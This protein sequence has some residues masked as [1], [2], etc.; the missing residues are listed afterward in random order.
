PEKLPLSAK[1]FWDAFE[2]GV[3]N[4][5]TTKITNEEEKEQIKKEQEQQEMIAKKS[6]QLEQ[7]QASERKDELVNTIKEKMGNIRDA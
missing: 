5:R 6:Q 1:S 2:L 4:S 3:K 7:S